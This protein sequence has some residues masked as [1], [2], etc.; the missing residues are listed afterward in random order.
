MSTLPT[1]LIHIHSNTHTN[2][3][4]L[5]VRCDAV[6]SAEISERLR[7]A[8]YQGEL[9]GNKD[10]R[11]A[12]DEWGQGQESGTHAKNVDLKLAPQ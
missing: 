2:T 12:K 8:V 3:W 1:E 4:S 7:G 11:V 10:T 6:S 9:M 5:W